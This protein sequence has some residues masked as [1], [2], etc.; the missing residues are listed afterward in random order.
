V[1]RITIAPT[2]IR[3]FIIPVPVG[4]SPEPFRQVKPGKYPST[5]HKPWRPQQHPPRRLSKAEVLRRFLDN[6]NRQDG[7]VRAF[8]ATCG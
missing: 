7:E 2:A 4:G 6:I 5:Q 8:M 1:T 3:S